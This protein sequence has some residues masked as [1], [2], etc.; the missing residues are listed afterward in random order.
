MDAMTHEDRATHDTTGDEQLL[1][2]ADRNLAEFTKVQA[3]WTLA[4]EVVAADDVQLVASETRFPVGMFNCMVPVGPPPDSARARAW[5]E[6]ARAFFAA[7]DRGFT[8]YVRGT[9]DAALADA[10]TA[11]G[12]SAMP[13]S[14]GMVLDAPLPESPL[15]GV[16]IARVADAQGVADLI[17]VVAPAYAM[18]SM[19]E[20][21]TQN[22]FSDAR[23]VLTPEIAL[24]VAYLDGAPA[25]TAISLLSH[26]IA[27]IY[28]VA[29]RPDS[30]RR[31]LGDAVTRRAG[32]DALGRGAACVVLQASKFGEPVYRRMGY[33]EITRYGWMF[34]SR[35]QL[36]GGKEVA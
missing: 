11:L 1:Q 34:M 7:R 22:I 21:V 25:A 6:R 8:A 27:G 12:M 36:A 5:L 9:R 26:G 14:P 16:R 32:N 13:A 33:R 17:A 19:P 3:L 24:Y 23:R 10:C 2:L 18:L 15:P 29:T 28:W 4:G 20:P 35:T 31:G 30:Q